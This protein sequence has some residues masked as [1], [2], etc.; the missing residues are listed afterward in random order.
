MTLFGRLIALFLMLVVI[1]LFTVSAC[2]LATQRTLRDPAVYTSTFENQNIFDDIVPEVLPAIV[3]AA[4]PGSVAAAVD[5][6][7]VDLRAIVTALSRD[8]MREVTTRLIPPAWLQAQFERFIRTV[9]KIFENDLTVLDAPIDLSE[10]KT[11]LVG[12]SAQSAAAYIL[13][14]APDCT[15]DQI[16]LLEA[17][18]RGERQT[19]PICHSTDEALQAVGIRTLT[20]WMAT[21]S[22]M[23]PQD[24][25]TTGEFFDVSTQEARALQIFAELDMQLVGFLYLCP[26]ALTG[27]IVFCAVRSL[28]GFGRWL[29]LTAVLTGSAIFIL[30]VLMQVLLVGLLSESGSSGSEAQRLAE[31]LFAGLIRALVSGSSSLM[32]LQAGLFGAA[33]FVLL[34]VSFLVRAPHV[35]P[36]PA[37]SV[38]ITDDGEIISTASRPKHSSSARMEPPAP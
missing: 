34:A 13:N 22:T 36:I 10:L 24:G 20:E 16:A 30:L 31:R 17:M 19:L 4:A 14:N 11:R 27:L 29:G 18:G 5:N 33:G 23:L 6:S 26:L 1:P 7:T 15:T 25:I 21:V 2:G 38:I 37:G 8:D 35:G 32:L 9:L 12:D 28:K 3:A